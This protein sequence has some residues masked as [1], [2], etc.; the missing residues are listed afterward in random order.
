MFEVF[1][2]YPLAAFSRGD[3][4]FAARWPVWLLLILIVAAAVA[5]AL[6]LWRNRGT[7]NIAPRVKPVLLWLLQT[8]MVAILLVLL[9]QP[10]LSVATLRP[11]Q[12]V[13]AVV[14]DDSKSMAIVEDS[15]S[16]AD[17]ARQAMNGAVLDDLSKKF[18]VRLYRLG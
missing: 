7:K 13:V 17:R 4:V 8:A 12:N 15:V 1:F 18:Q 14:V 2:K 6:P 11:Q 9:W 10:A 16:R 3:V 5:F